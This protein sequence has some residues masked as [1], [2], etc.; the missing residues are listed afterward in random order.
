[1]LPTADRLATLTAIAAF[2]VAWNRAG[3]EDSPAQ[4]ELAGRSADGRFHFVEATPDPGLT[5]ITHAGRPGKDHLLDSA[6]SGAGWL[7]YDRDGWIDLYVVNAWKVDG[8]TI[9]ERGRH[10]LY[11]NHGDGTFEDVTAKAGVAGEGHWGSGVAIA[12]YDR[13]GWPDLLV[14]HFGPNMLYRNRGD[15]TFVNVAAEAGVESPGWNTGAAFL[16]ADGDGDLDLYVAA[17]IDC[18]LE[19]FL[20]ARPTLDWKGVDKVA[21]GPFGLKG[22]PDHFFRAEEGDRFVEATKEAGLE[23]RSL[24]FG[25]GVRAADFDA[26]GDLDLYVAND[27]DANYL[28]R[29]DGGKFTEVGLFSGAAFDANANA[30]A[31]MGVTVGDVGGD[32][33]LDIFTTNFSEDFST[34]Y[35]GCGGCFFEDVTRSTGVGPPTYKM[36][37]WGTVLADFDNDGDLDLAVCNGHIYPQVDRHPEIGISYAQPNLLLEN[38]G[39]GQFRDVTASAGPGFALVQCSRGLAAGDYD[40]DGDIDLL[41]THLDQRPTLL[42]NESTVGSWLTVICE[43]Q[44]HGCPPVG[45]SIEV[46]AGQKRWMRDVSSSDS[47]LCAPDPRLH[48]GLGDIRTVDEVTVRWTDRTVTAL[49]NVA[50]NR[51]LTVSK[52]QSSTAPGAAV[53]K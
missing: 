19:E 27:S 48:F 17:Y 3:A 49:T 4:P 33:I 39:G 30:Q 7:D 36:L 5:H 13:N 6:G 34:L 8:R 42:R 25:F 43:D 16:D 12:D 11:R 38:T 10:A 53:E 52:P 24:G 32:G 41:I 22:A 15:G 35:Q 29:N 40:N 2:A 14:T 9:L 37:S 23:D 45:T 26:D 44:P 47:F 46:R 20:N 21:F 50:C 28:Y 31:S 51:F 18:T 1:M